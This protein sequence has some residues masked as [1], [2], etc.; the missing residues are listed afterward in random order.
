MFFS[1]KWSLD[2]LQF[3][4]P[5]S[6]PYQTNPPHPDDIKL[7]IQEEREGRVT[8]IRHEKVIDVEENQILTR[9]IMSERYN[10]AYFIAKRME[11]VTKQPQL[12]LPYGRSSISS[13]SDFGQPS[14]SHP[15][16]DDDGNDEGTSCA[17]TPSPTLYV[18]SL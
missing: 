12:I 5:T 8:R 3:N 18:N 7:Y 15:N 4:V 17:S 2:D 1:D 10:L 6:G 16:D 13:S 11:L 9:E 14:S